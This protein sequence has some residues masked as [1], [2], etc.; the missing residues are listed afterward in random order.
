MSTTSTPDWPVGATYDDRRHVDW[1]YCKGTK[2]AEGITQH[3]QAWAVMHRRD[4]E[5]PTLLAELTEQAEQASEH[6]RQVA[7]DPSVPLLEVFEAAEQASRTRASAAALAELIEDTKGSMPEAMTTLLAGIE[8]RAI[9]RALWA[10]E[11][12]DHFVMAVKGTRSRPDLPCAID[13]LQAEA[14]VVEALLEERETLLVTMPFDAQQ[15]EAN[16]ARI[17]Q[18]E[19]MLGVEAGHRKKDTERVLAERGLA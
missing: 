15:A 19:K 8:E 13:I 9:E 1:A 17:E 6:A 18:I 7:G 3:E 12:R 2:Q 10:K 14:K 5:L 4:R 16:Q 11:C